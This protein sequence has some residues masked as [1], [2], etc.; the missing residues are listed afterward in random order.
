MRC[1]PG[2]YKARHV[3]EKKEYRLL[4][5]QILVCSRQNFIQQVSSLEKMQELSMFS[6]D[7]AMVMFITLFIK[8][9]SYE[10]RSFC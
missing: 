3:A 7:T 10:I 4:H 8:K 6:T 5:A 2:L 9:K 1:W